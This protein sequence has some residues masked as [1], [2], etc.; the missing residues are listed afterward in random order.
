MVIE[1]FST[2]GIC[3]FYGTREVPAGGGSFAIGGCGEGA[4]AYWGRALNNTTPAEAATLAALLRG[5][6]Y[7]NPWRH[8]D[9][10]VDRRN[11]ILGLM[12][13]NGYLTDREYAVAIETPLKLS[14][15]GAESSDA[16]YFVDLVNDELQ[17]RFQDYDF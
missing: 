7:Y 10:I 1:R 9:R 15:S 14:S 4:Y 8:R 3:C 5:A 2:K 17:N 11:M 13:Q 16:P 6:S 12:R